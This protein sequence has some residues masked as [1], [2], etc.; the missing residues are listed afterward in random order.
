[1]VHPRLMAITV[2]SRWWLPLVAAAVLPLMILGLLLVPEQ[3][4]AGSDLEIVLAAAASA[5][6]LLAIVGATYLSRGS[7]RF[8]ADAEGLHIESR[9][10]G[11]ASIAWQELLELGWVVPGEYAPGGLAGRRRRG[12]AYDTGGPNIAGWL[13]Q[14]TGQIAPQAISELQALCQQHG[15]AWRRYSGAEVM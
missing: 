5:V 12:G 1:M 11:T 10:H 9:K 7:D 6:L 13:C 2:R 3:E 14:P 4:R 15:V 8:S